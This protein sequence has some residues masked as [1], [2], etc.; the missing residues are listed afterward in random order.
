LRT[1]SIASS[2]VEGLQVDARSLA[3]AESR[4]DIGGRVSAT[5]SEVLANIDAMQL[6]VEDAP[7]QYE[8]RSIADFT[9]SSLLT[10][11]GRCFNGNA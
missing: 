6:A 9:S 4:A 10:S 2:K 5:A 8:V 11:L 3:R 1:E 7:R